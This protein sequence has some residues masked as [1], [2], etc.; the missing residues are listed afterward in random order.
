MVVCFGRLRKLFIFCAIEHNLVMQVCGWR[1]SGRLGYWP[2]RGPFSFL[3]PWERPGWLYGPWACWWFH[4]QRPYRGEATV[5]EDLEYLKSYAEE[6]K[7]ALE[8][9]ES[10]IKSLESRAKGN[11]P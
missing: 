7:L 11:M 4:T 6:L 5:K 3:P 10:K 1:R 8:E 9:V 2:G